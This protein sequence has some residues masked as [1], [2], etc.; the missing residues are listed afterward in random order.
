MNLAEQI[1]L[2]HCSMNL[3][4]EIKYFLG[5]DYAQL[6]FSETKGSISIDSVIV[7]FTHRG[8]GVGTILI[9][10]ILTLAD[11][12]RKEVYISARPIGVCDEERLQRLVRFYEQ[13]DFCKYDRGVTVVY[14]KRS[15][16]EKV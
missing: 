6:K 8:R 15:V 3:S 11:G 2:H 4:G 12:I 13:F 1:I 14:M 9:Q 7:P 5:K 10:R 16:V